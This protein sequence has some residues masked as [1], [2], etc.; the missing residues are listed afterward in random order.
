MRARNQGTISA[1]GGVGALNGAGGAANFC[2]SKA[3]LTIAMQGLRAEVAHLG[4]RVCL[5]QLGH[6]RT[7]FLEAGH[8]IKTQKSLEDYQPLMGPTG[9]AFDALNGTQQGSPTSAGK[10][11][12]EVLSGTGRA[13][14]REMPEYLELGADVRA[15]T[16]QAQAFRDSQA[17]AWEDI[18]TST[19]L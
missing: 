3:G 14:G 13:A 18:G 5:I 9:R 11:I 7:A 16:L 12:V 1:V 19:D 15:A 17:S 8:R 6:F 10:A 4:I 2:A